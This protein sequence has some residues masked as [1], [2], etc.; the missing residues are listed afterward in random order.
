VKSN[1]N[2]V[3][4]FECDRKR[5]RGAKQIEETEQMIRRFGFLISLTACM[6]ACTKRND[7]VDRFYEDLARTKLQGK[8]GFV[9]KSQK[10]VIPR[11]YEMV[12]S[13]SEGLA[14]VQ[15]GKKWGYIDHSGK[16]V[17]PAQFD[18]AKRF[19]GKFAVVSK[20]GKW[21]WIDKTGRTVAESEIDLI[22]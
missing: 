16:L 6:L 2:R 4:G 15:V 5:A 3:A 20:R 21:I 18:D 1:V 9:D 22:P 10:L 19:Q 13:F 14:A 7:Y 12:R 11:Q 17:I 8:W